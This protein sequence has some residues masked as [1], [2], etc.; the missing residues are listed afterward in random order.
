MTQRVDIA[1][2]AEGGV[3]LRGWLYLP[4]GPGPHPAITM[5]HGYAS[6]KEHGLER[7]R[8]GL[9]RG[10]L[11]GAAA[12]P[13]DVRGQRRR[14]AAGRGP[15]AAD[16][17]LAPRGLLPGEPAAGRRRADRPVGHQLRRRPRHRP[18]RHRPSPAVRRRPGAHDQRVRAGPA[19]RPAGRRRRPGG[20]ARRG[21]AGPVPRRGAPDAGDRQRRPRGLGRLPGQGRDRVLPPAGARGQL[22]EPGD[23]PVHPCGPHVR[24]G[25][26]DQPSLA[27]TAVAR[28]RRPRH[29]HRE[30]PGAGRLPARAGAEETSAAPRRALRPLP[31]Q[32]RGV[33]RRGSRLVPPA[34]VLAAITARTP[35]SQQ[36]PARS[37]ALRRK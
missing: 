12:R 36:P 1:F 5:G 30:R 29:H 9:R 21:R 20:R 6:V 24:A 25:R 35:V 8:R 26:V 31:V 28:G 16:R 2:T 14:A 18:G 27:D 15:V 34:R 7:F 23:C 22:G 37:R 3:T 4:E 32:V 11:R 10:R 17:R 19:P 13:P 33:Q